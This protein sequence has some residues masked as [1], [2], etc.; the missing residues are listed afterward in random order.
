MDMGSVVVFMCRGEIIQVKR[1]VS[2]KQ[3][4]S[5]IRVEKDPHVLKRLFFIKYRYEGDHVSVAA[6]K[7]L[8]DKCTGYDWQ[9]RWNQQGYPG[10]KPRYGGGACMKLS[11]VQVEDLKK[12]LLEKGP[13]STGEAK[14]LILHKYGVEYTIKQ[15]WVILNKLGMYH[16]KPRTRDYRKPADAIGI[17]KNLDEGLPGVP[18]ILGF[19]DETSSRIVRMMQRLWSFVKAEVPINLNAPRL[20]IFG[21]LAYNGN[22]LIRFKKNSKTPKHMRIPTGDSRCER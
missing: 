13:V 12:V 17:L 11:D 19:F 18:F 15:V 20:N 3:L 14:L 21:F 1:R 2:L 4:E 6:G 5:M 10:L 8:V 9:E 22:S 16:A 7:V